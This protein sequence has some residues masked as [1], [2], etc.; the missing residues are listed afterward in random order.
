MPL[1]KGHYERLCRESGL[2][3]HARGLHRLRLVARLGWLALPLGALL[4]MEFTHLVWPDPP[5]LIHSGM[6]ALIDL[7]DY[8]CIY[9]LI[10][11]GCL[12]KDLRDVAL[13]GALVGGLGPTDVTTLP[14]ATSI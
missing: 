10:C 5:E 9:L 13:L 8:A 14:E 11:L 7:Y 1:N 6:L 12:V 4:M 3:P 2:A